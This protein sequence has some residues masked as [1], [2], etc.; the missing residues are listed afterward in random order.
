MK[1]CFVSYVTREMQIKTA[2]GCHR[3]P[4]RIAQIQY[5][6]TTKHSED[7]KQQIL[8]FI[9]CGKAKWYRTLGDSLADSNKTN[10]TLTL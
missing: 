5:A 4:A 3:L 7:V 8:S 10:Q 6:D 1:S 2:M 9:A